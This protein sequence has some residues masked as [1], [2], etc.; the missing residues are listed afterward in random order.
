MN[1]DKVIW[2][3]KVSVF[4]NKSSR[5]SMGPKILAFVSHCLANFHP[6]L[7]CFLLNFM[8]KYENSENVKVDRVDTVAFNL[9]QIKRCMGVFDGTP[10]IS[11]RCCWY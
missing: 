6:I 7:D 5:G 9:H 2:L 10:G 4:S 8:L 3:L 1:F 11:G